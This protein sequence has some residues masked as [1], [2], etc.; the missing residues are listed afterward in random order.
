MRTRK[1]LSMA[2]GMVMLTSVGAVGVAGVANAADDTFTAEGP[3]VVITTEPS[4]Q[5]L[6]SNTYELTFKGVSKRTPVTIS[7]GDGNESVATTSCTRKQAKRQPKKC[8]V[9]AQHTY[10]EAGTYYAIARQGGADI[11]TE[12]V[13]VNVGS[14]PIVPPAP[15]YQ[16]TSE[17]RSRM[18]TR[19]NEVRAANGVGPVGMCPRLDQVAQD[20]AQLMA[21]TGHYGHT[22]P[23]GESP[24]DR[25]RAGGYDYRAAAENIAWGYPTA[26]RVQEGWEGSPGHFKNMVSPNVSD[27]GL[28]AAESSSG[29]W[30]WVQVYGTGGTCDLGG[31][32]IET[33]AQVAL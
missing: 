3:V 20:Y 25:M 10:E 33:E 24:W 32:R 30:Y 14:T 26:D 6:A 29:R 23:G 9:R 5:T 17:W 11:K 4:Q 2:A 18:S 28:G 19:I 8:Q 7:W 16:A 27:V 13:T 22:G 15:Q 1:W 12:W 31:M 21:D